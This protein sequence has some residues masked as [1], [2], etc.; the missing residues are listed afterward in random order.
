MDNTINIDQSLWFSKFP[1]YKNYQKTY[2]KRYKKQTIDP[3]ELFVEPLTGLII[4]LPDPKDL[5]A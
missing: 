4:P 3:V 1:Q 2:F 5:L